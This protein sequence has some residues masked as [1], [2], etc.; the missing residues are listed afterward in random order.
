MVIP[1]GEVE[2]FSVK[3]KLKYLSLSEV[4]KKF[5]AEQGGHIFQRAELNPDMR[6]QSQAMFHS[7]IGNELEECM[8]FCAQRVDC[9][10]ILYRP[11]RANK[12]VFLVHY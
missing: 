11:E 7:T 10:Y 8:V 4:Y 2:S 9:V 6:S 3:L 1:T 5:T 12:C